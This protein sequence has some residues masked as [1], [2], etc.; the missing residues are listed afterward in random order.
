MVA[1]SVLLAAGG[2][3]IGVPSIFQRRVDSIQYSHGKHVQGI[4]RELSVYLCPGAAKS[5]WFRSHNIWDPI[6]N[7]HSS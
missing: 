7:S 1:D 4:P 3:R 5:A 2:I 6:N